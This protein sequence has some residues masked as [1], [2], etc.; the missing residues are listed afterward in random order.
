[1]L[2][3][4][5][6]LNAREALTLELLDEACAF[7]LKENEDYDS[8]GWAWLFL[9]LDEKYRKDYEK[10]ERR[11]RKLCAAE[12][13]LKAALDIDA[14]PKWVLP[15]CDGECLRRFGLAAWFNP[16][17]PTLPYSSSGVGWFSLL[18]P[19]IPASSDDDRWLT[20]RDDD[21]YQAAYVEQH[22]QLQLAERNR[23]NSQIESFVAS[24]YRR[25]VFPDYDGSCRRLYGL[26]A[27]LS[28]S[29]IKLPPLRN[30]GSWFFP[31]KALVLENYNRNNVFE[32]LN[33]DPSFPQFPIRDRNKASYIFLG[34]R[35][36]PFGY[37]R[38][39]APLM[40]SENGNSLRI[41]W[42]AVDC[43][44]PVAGQLSVL[45]DLAKKPPSIPKRLRPKNL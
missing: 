7:A 20:L 37:G 6:V 36:T 45:R 27:W 18:S 28:P 21:E 39:T 19:I 11:E 13:H 2:S 32:P 17:L 42:A 3:A 43:S 31:L 30:N 29:S 16:K 8:D 35:E 4:Q 10:H 22:R 24:K 33:L 40:A 41:L 34:T 15:D 26:A 12:D 44:I 23:A 14:L 9:S 25:D 38:A 5:D 1:M